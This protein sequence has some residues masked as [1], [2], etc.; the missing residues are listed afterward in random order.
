VIASN[1]CNYRLNVLIDVGAAVD[2]NQRLQRP[3]RY[4]KSGSKRSVDRT[5]DASDWLV[6]QQLGRY[7]RWRV[8][9]KPAQDASLG[10]ERM[11]ASGMDGQRFGLDWIARKCPVAVEGSGITRHVTETA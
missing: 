5:S 2:E 11:R 10:T 7:S 8:T 1:R 4:L 3:W 6:A 9:L